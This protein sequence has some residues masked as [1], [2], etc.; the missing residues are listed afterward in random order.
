MTRVLLAATSAVVRAGLEALLERHG[1]DIAG[2]AADLGS[3][4]EIAESVGAD[5]V[6]VEVDGPLPAHDLPVGSEWSVPLV[7]VTDEIA[8]ARRLLRE[9][10]RGIIPP[11]SSGEQIAAAVQAAA[12]GLVVLPLEAT[13]SLV[14]VGAAVA[15]AETL[16]PRETEVLQML[17]EGDGNKQIARRLGISDHT[18]KFHVASIMGK[19]G[20]DTRTEAVTLGIRQGLIMV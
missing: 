20:A 4:A 5:V 9:N 2:S 16:T 11:D 12:L 7:L 13:V 18:V 15:T 17:A 19:L 14:P 1:F 3:L 6:L 8:D 10:V